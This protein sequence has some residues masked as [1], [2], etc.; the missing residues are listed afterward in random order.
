MIIKARHIPFFVSFFS[1][2]SRNRLKRHFNDVIFECSISTA[3][4]PVLLIGNHFSWW[5]GFIAYRLNDL[6]LH[7]KFHIMMLEEQLEHR[8]FLN[9]AGA[10]S[11]KRGSRT[12]VETLSYTSGLLHDADNMVVMYPQGVITSIHRRPVRFE[13][14][15]ERVI[16]GA[17]DK[18][19]ILF[20][21]ALPDWYSEKKPGLYVRVIEYAARERAITDLEE[22]YNMFLD[23]CI[24][25]QIPS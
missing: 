11:I 3:G 2:Y 21:V 24:A 25:N 15:T 18:L 12:V 6:F 14:G 13:K 4:R 22:A 9:K 7:K 1:F 19:M 17:S 10:F 23:E 16:A 20:Y 8:L 5:D